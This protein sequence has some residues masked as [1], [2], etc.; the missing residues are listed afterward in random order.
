MPCSSSKRL[1]ST[2]PWVGWEVQ[3]ERRDD[4]TEQ[5][6][7]SAV[8]DTLLP[9]RTAT[10]DS[11]FESVAVFAPDGHLQLWNRRFAAD[12]GLEDNFL[13]EHPRI[14]SLRA[15]PLKAQCI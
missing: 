11:L 5:L 6:R 1:G 12:W 2:G 13:D 10:F 14:E 3:H 9:T 15:S 4:R 8:R 7:L